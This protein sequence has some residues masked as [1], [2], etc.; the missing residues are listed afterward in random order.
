MFPSGATSPV[1]SMRGSL[2]R[3]L[4][5][6]RT[7]GMTMLSR[8]LSICALGLFLGV[9]PAVAQSTQPAVPE[10]L[11]AGSDSLKEGLKAGSA[12]FQAGLD[13]AADMAKE[14]SWLQ[15]LSPEQRKDL[16]EFVAG[17]L[18]FTLAH[19]LG[20]ALIT[21]MGLYVLGREEDAADS[22]AIFGMLSVGSLVSDRILTH[23]TTGWFLSDERNQ[24]QGIGL[25]FYDEHSL[26]RQ[27][28]YEIVCL[29]V[30]SDPQRFAEAAIKANLPEDR[31]E[32]C[33]GDYSN[34]SWSWTTALKPHLR[35]PDKPKQ[36][37]NV[38]Y[39]P[40]EAQYEPLV[41][42]F[43]TI[44]LLETGADFAANRYVWRRP[45]T[46]EMSTCGAPSAGFDL[47]AQ[48]ITIC[49]ELALDFAMLY[50]DYGL[51]GAGTASHK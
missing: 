8:T 21:E 47:R 15:D 44:R 51:A 22:Y 46:F 39:G 5:N 2:R 20:H 29:M 16:I 45:I 37:I 10:N 27:R 11:K 33:Q 40:V 31:Q 19:E 6:A 43:R 48:K 35:S 12:R 13:Q 30:G 32:T 24:K 1:R 50:R 41:K 17:N 42:I 9:C 14:I 25:A 18:L 23:A 49:Y 36:T 34:V 38:V 4:A 28:A 26:D 7:Q 3:L